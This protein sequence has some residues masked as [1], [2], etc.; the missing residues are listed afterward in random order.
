M[1]VAVP[2]SAGRLSMQFGHCEQFAILEV[3]ESTGKILTKSVHLPPPHEPGVLPRW[4]Y[5]LGADLVIAADMGQR[6]RKLLSNSGISVIVGASAETPEQLVSSYLN[7][8][9]RPGASPCDH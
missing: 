3:D 7:N 6:A 9:L 4:L 8:K 1:R 5:L 2:L